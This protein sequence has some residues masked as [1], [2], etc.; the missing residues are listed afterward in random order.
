M[1]PPHWKPVTFTVWSL[2]SAPTSMHFTRS[3]PAMLVLPTVSRP[4]KPCFHLRSLPLD[5]IFREP[6]GSLPH[7]FRSLLKGLSLN[8]DHPW[9]PSFKY[10]PLSP[11]STP[12][13]PLPATKF[14]PYHL[15]SH[16]LGILLIWYRL[17]LLHDVR[18]FYSTISP[19]YKWVSETSWVFN[20]YLLNAWKQWMRGIHW[21]VEWIAT[22][23]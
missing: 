9:P 16:I 15:S 7:S 21:A 20:K 23:S 3:A 17:C 11:H 5:S 8:G 14:S 12:V 1:V 19:L 13:H 10:Q 2:T 18:D 4:C 22:D 6:R